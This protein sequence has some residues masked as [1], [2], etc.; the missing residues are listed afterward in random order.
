MPCSVV[1]AG[2]SPVAAGLSPV[3]AG[4]SPVA[5][6]L[7]FFSAE[8]SGRLCEYSNLLSQ[9]L[10]AFQD[11]RSTCCMDVIKLLSPRLTGRQNDWAFY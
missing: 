2:L 1:A 6:G 3:A 4:L 11:G 7:T 10:S 9:Q 5:A 8:T